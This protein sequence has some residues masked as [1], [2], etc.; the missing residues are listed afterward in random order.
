[1]SPRELAQVLIRVMGIGFLAFGVLTGC[2][3]IL[4]FSS[5]SKFWTEMRTFALSSVGLE[6]VIAIF[7]IRQADWLAAR[8]RAGA[9]P[10]EGAPP[11]STGTAL[12]PATL[13]RVG[14]GLIGVFCLTRI[15]SPI[16]S[17]I[18]QL[19][20]L[21]PSGSFM[22]ALS[23]ARDPGRSVIEL[24]VNLAFAIVLIVG[25]GRVGRRL[26]RIGNWI[27]RTFT[28]YRSPSDPPPAP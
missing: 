7:L 5:D 9:E 16:A 13:F 6:F 26:A 28:A 20:R 4:Q 22:D 23:P 8:F 18:Y 15:A 24:V 27:R 12:D 25:P 3:M 17:I 2:L 14:T 1:M 19:T 10:A 21:G 11:V